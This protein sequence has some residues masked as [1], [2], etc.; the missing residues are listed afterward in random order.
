MG[1]EVVLFMSTLHVSFALTNL[2]LNYLRLWTSEKRTTFLRT[3]FWVKSPCG[4]F[5]RNQ[6]S[7]EASCLLLQPWRWRQH[8]SPKRCFLRTSPDGDLC[9]KNTIRIVTA[10]KILNFKTITSSEPGSDLL[11][12]PTLHS[13]ADIMVACDR[14]YDGDSKHQAISQKT[15][16]FIHAAVRIWN[17][18]YN[19]FALNQGFV[20]AWLSSQDALWN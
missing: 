4:L 6:R 17:L 5:G 16:I 20:N 12:C 18:P 10:V 11:V 19:Y 14:P 7:G 13:L 8:G 3:L 15:T 1:K 2:L 9:Q